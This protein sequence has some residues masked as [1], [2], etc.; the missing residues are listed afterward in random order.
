MQAWLDTSW[1]AVGLSLLTLLIIYLGVLLLTRLVGLRSFSK[2]SAVDFAMTVA[3]GSMIA[4]AIS[5]PSPSLLLALAGLAGIFGIRWLLAFTRVHWPGLEQQ[6]EN[7][8]LLLM[9]GNRILDDNLKRAQ[10][11]R[12]DLRAKLREA[13]VLNY[14]QVR[15]VIFETT[16]DVSV[17]HSADPQERLD[18][19]LLEGVRDSHLLKENQDQ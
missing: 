5:A 7:S 15:A 18:P 19:A 1:S 13:N 10:V 6:L 12:A 11:S 4:G 16:G 9:A 14:D 17:L 8:P 2:M 3:I